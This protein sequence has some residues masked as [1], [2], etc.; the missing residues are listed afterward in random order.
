MKA[1]FQREKARSFLLANEDEKVHVP[2]L[3]FTPAQLND[4]KIPFFHSF[5]HT[6][7]FRLERDLVI[8]LGILCAP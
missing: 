1:N 3:M 8:E 2:N 7:A 6:I 4:R 5:L